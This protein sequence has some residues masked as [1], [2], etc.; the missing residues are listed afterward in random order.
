MYDSTYDGVVD[1]CRPPGGGTIR[2]L[3]FS[4]SKAVNEPFSLTIDEHAG[5]G[6]TV[7]KSNELTTDQTVSS[8][9]R[10]SRATS[11]ACSRWSSRRTRRRR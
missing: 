6:Q 1:S 2:A 10:G 9:P 8:T 11:S 5:G 7:I 3:K 4:M